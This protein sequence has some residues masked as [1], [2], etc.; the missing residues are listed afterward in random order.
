MDR[1]CDQFEQAWR[2]GE[3]PSLE[4]FL[5]DYDGATRTALLQ[6]L[7]SVEIEH[8]TNAGIA[9]DIANYHQSFPSDTAVFDEVLKSR[10]P[11]E[12]RSTTAESTDHS[13]R[14]Q[15]TTRETEDEADRLVGHKIGKYELRKRL[16]KGGMGIVLQAF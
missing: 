7:L 10:S 4:F 1:V 3:R 15:T 8:L 2:T 14:H 9:W 6:E 16:G 11:A 5:A 13:N 12:S